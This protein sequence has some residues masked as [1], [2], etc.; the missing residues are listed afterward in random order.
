MGVLQNEDGSLGDE[1]ATAF[2]VCTMLNFEV[3]PDS[4]MGAAVAY[5]VCR[6]RVTGSWPISAFYAARKD[7]VWWGSEEMTTAI[8]LE[9]L[10][11]Y[12][13]ALQASRS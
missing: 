8:C 6:Q 1:L 10:A 4:S 12:Q 2:G 13:R 5:L 7:G 11:R 9:A 3:P